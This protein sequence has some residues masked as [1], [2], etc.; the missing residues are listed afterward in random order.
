M[1]LESL[2]GL[3]AI[4]VMIHHAR[5]LLWEGFTNGYLQHK[6]QFS[7]LQKMLVYFM[8]V[9]SFGHEM[10]LFFFILSGFVIHLKFSKNLVEGDSSFNLKD[11]FFRRFKRIYPPLVL[12]IVLT[13]SLDSF[14][15]KLGFSIY[16]N[17]SIFP[18]VQ[19][20]FTVRDFLLNFFLI[21]DSYTGGW[22]SDFPL[23]SLKFEWWFYILFPLFFQLLKRSTAFSL[24][25]IG[26]LFIVSFFPYLW[27]IKFLQEIFTLMIVW[28]LGVVLADIYT[29][30][31]KIKFQ[32]ISILFFLI[33]FLLLFNIDYGRQI[34]DLLW[35]LGFMG[36]L[37]FLFYLNDRNRAL[38]L[39]NSISWLGSFSFSLYIIHA[40]ILV[41]ISGYILKK[42]GELPL[43]FGYVFM[44]ISICLLASYIAHLF[45]EVPF[46]SKK[47]IVHVKAVS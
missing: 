2:R 38:G 21:M 46:I 8:S 40:P 16:S 15:K 26:L 24:F 30:R 11:Y 17:E 9:F 37:S 27:P 47:K 20:N 39:L 13:F 1:F 43:H 18:I 5:W 32:Y 28:W 35:G 19:D 22:G 45:V 42:N 4:Y 3:A 23:W 10:V 6:E 12:A 7:F 31:C 34:I 29:S 41:F 33:P 25:V 44:G 36:F 14:G